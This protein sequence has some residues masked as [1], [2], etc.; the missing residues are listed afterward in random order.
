MKINKLKLFLITYSFFFISLCS[1][2]KCTDDYKVDFGYVKCWDKKELG[3]IETTRVIKLDFQRDPEDYSVGMDHIVFLKLEPVR[4]NWMEDP[5]DLATM[6]LRDRKISDICISNVNTINSLGYSIIFYQNIFNENHEIK[7]SFFPPY[8]NSKRKKWIDYVDKIREE[9][10]KDREK[11][12]D[13][14]L[15][16]LNNQETYESDEEENH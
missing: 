10:E 5:E 7:P 2:I 9:I 13:R 16:Y 11:I 14:W 12:I 15:D 4:I 1:E 6:V 3:E 8:N